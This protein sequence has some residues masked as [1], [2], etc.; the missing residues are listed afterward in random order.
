MKM[1][2]TYQAVFDQ[3]M[4]RKPRTGKKM[5]ETYMQLILEFYDQ[6]RSLAT[7]EIL[8]ILYRYQKDPLLRERLQDIYQTYGQ[9]NFLTSRLKPADTAL[10]KRRY[11]EE[12]T[13]FTRGYLHAVAA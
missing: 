4:M 13:K 3:I 1:I 5:I 8:D 11:I 2:S 12:V 7:I 9:T 6:N 10:I